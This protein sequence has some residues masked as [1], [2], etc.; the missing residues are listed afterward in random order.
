MLIE[1]DYKRKPTVQEITHGISPF[2]VLTEERRRCVHT[3]Y[4]DTFDWRLYRKGLTLKTY[5]CDGNTEISLHDRNHGH[6]VS[7][8]VAPTINVEKLPTG[9]LQDRVIP[10]IGIRSLM[11]RLSLDGATE[12]LSIRN[13]SGKTVAQC[14][15]STWRVVNDEGQSV[16]KPLRRLQLE[17]LKGYDAEFAEIQN[18]LSA[19]SGLLPTTDTLLDRGL[20]KLGRTACDYSTKL[21]YGFSADTPTLQAAVEIFTALYAII[22]ANEKGIERDID[23]EFLHDFRIAIRRT[24]SLLAQLK[25]HFTSSAIRNFGEEFSW[26]GHMTNAKRDYDIFGLKIPVYESLVCSA[27]LDHL[28]GLG[29]YIETQRNS[30]LQALLEVL[31]G[32]R[33][34]RLKTEWE[35]FLGEPHNYVD[36]AECNTSVKETADVGIWAAYKQVIR[37]GRPIRPDSPFELF[38]KLRIKCKRLRYLLEF[39]AHIYSNTDMRR[40]VKQLKS[41]QDMLGE[42]QDQA[43][44]ITHLRDFGVGFDNTMGAGSTL[45]IGA[46]IQ[47]ISLSADE[48]SLIVSEFER[49]ASRNNHRLYRSL[50]NNE[51][52]YACDRDLQH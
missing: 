22:T 13:D 40:L 45:A 2:T 49:F 32:T 7:R 43:F 31:H 3:S 33:Y 39:Y 4:L 18:A 38:H 35:A 24:R 19:L 17:D 29:D 42:L 41:L 37:A 25:H 47:A 48:R 1:F 44:Q 46:L 10:I 5:H 26:L 28:R 8:A 30:T 52:T 23:T 6:C 50:F 14:S 36:A 20:Q 27:L 15:L 11:T 21:Q 51:P 16:S 12:L 9:Q 34:Q